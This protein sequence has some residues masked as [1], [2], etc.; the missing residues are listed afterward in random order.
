MQVLQKKKERIEELTTYGLTYK[1]LF[2]KKKRRSRIRKLIFS[3]V[4]RGF[5]Q[6][7]T[8]FSSGLSRSSLGR[9]TGSL[10]TKRPGGVPNGDLPCSDDV[11]LM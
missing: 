3:V 8:V 5:L 4:D 1:Y 10:E 7:T 2:I 6:I 9:K 11:C